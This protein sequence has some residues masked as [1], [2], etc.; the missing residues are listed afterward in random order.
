LETP[1]KLRVL[2]NPSAG[3]GAGAEH[4]DR[5]RIVA[6]RLDAGLVVSRRPLDVVEGARAAVRDGI[7]RLLVFGG[8]GTMH[9][10]AQ[11][12][13]G[14]GTALGVIPLG[15]GND[16]ARAL[17]MPRRMDRAIEAAV[18]APIRRIDLVRVGDLYCIGYAGV[19]FDSE[20]AGFANRVR[21]LR[22]PL[23]YVY[24]LVRTLI[25]FAPPAMRVV[26]DEGTFEGR[27]MFAVANNLPT[28]GGGMRIAPDARIDDGLLDL[29]IVRKIPKLTLLRIFPKVYSG[30]HVG[31][32]ACLVV[33]TRRVEITLDRE[34]TLFGGGE[35]MLPMRPGEPVA[36]E[37][38]PGGLAVVAPGETP[39]VRPV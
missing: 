15:T 2:V 36:I 17:E 8:D 30:R 9:L 1:A 13:A 19:G 12:L 14:S 6:S 34:M 31:H 7:E 28:F 18:R 32:A 23:V 29:V 16:L 27:V 39:A 25:S 33:K 3:R 38:V 26:H 37:I 10:A 11:G 5:I 21:K 4:L 22:G 24:A 20:V 35:P